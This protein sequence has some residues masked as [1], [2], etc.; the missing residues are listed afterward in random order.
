MMDSPLGKESSSQ[1]WKYR[2]PFPG[3]SHN[4]EKQSSGP[5]IYE[6][7]GVKSPLEELLEAEEQANLTS[8]TA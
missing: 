6:R 2:H 4:I 5:K 1:R 7:S 3:S 8:N